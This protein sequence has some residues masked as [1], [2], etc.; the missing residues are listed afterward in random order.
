MIDD[1][2]GLFGRFKH[3]ITSNTVF[4]RIIHYLRRQ[5]YLR[6][7]GKRG[8]SQDIESPA[9]ILKEVVSNLTAGEFT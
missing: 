1:D 4:T 6:S 9:V 7:R 2:G 8:F 3:S 5:G